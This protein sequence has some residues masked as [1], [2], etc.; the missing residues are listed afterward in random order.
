VLLGRLTVDPSVQGQG[1]GEGLLLDALER[2][3]VLYAGL[4]I[5]VAE[6]DAL[7]ATAAAFYRKFGF[8]ALRDNPLHLYLP[9]ATVELLLG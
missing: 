7:D 6:V 3:L 2:S 9:L 8:T 5:H 4:G 1:L